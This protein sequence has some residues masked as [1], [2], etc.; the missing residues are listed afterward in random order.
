[1]AKTP[2]TTSPEE[3]ALKD[4]E[5][6]HELKQKE[7]KETKLKQIPDYM[8]EWAKK[9]SGDRICKN[10]TVG[11]LWGQLSGGR[12]KPIAIKRAYEILHDASKRNDEDYEPLF[13]HLTNGHFKEF[14]EDFPRIAD[15]FESKDPDIRK[16]AREFVGQETLQGERAFLRELKRIK[17]EKMDDKD[18]ANQ[19]RAA[20]DLTTESGTKAE[21]AEAMKGSDLGLLPR[22]PEAGNIPESFRK[23]TSYLEESTK[24]LNKVDDLVKEAKGLTES[25][26]ALEKRLKQDPNS[27]EALLTEIIGDYDVLKRTAETM[28][29]TEKSPELLKALKQFNKQRRTYFRAQA[30]ANLE[31]NETLHQKYLAAKESSAAKSALMEAAKASL[32]P[33]LKTTLELEVK[34]AVDEEMFE[35]AEQK[36]DVDPNKF[37]TE[38]EK[39]KAKYGLQEV[40]AP[41]LEQD[42]VEKM[43]AQAEEFI[44]FEAA[45]AGARK[46]YMDN[47]FELTKWQHLC[48]DIAGHVDMVEKKSGIKLTEKQDGW[49]L[50]PRQ[51]TLAY[52]DYEMRT[53]VDRSAI[54]EMNPD[55]DQTSEIVKNETGQAKIRRHQTATIK[56]IKYVPQSYEEGEPAEEEDKLASAWKPETPRKGLLKITIETAEGT[57]TMGQ[58]E[59]LNWVAT[60]EVHEEIQEPKEVEEKVQETTGVRMKLEKGAKLVG[61]FGYKSPPEFEVIEIDKVEGD[62]VYLTQPV[63]FQSDQEMPYATSL[64]G[65]RQRKDLSLGE[66][67]SLIARRDLLPL[68]LDSE[69]KDMVAKLKKD[70]KPFW[71]NYGAKGEGEAR[72]LQLDG[73]LGDMMDKHGPGILTGA[74]A[75]AGL[76]ATQME[77]FKNHPTFSER[78]LDSNKKRFIKTHV[79]GARLMQL[80]QDYD[81]TD[82]E[83][84]PLLPLGDAPET[85]NE[86]Y[87]TP[88]QKEQLKKE[89]KDEAAEADDE[90][91]D[92]DGKDP[93]HYREEALNESELES[94][95]EAYIT[96]VG[97]LRGLWQR[98]RVLASDDIWGL[99][100]ACY[101]HYERRWHRRSKEKFS[102]VGEQLPLGYGTEMSR[103]KQQAE[104][105]EVNQNVE[106]MEDWG[107]GDIQETLRNAKNID[108]LKACYQILA[109]KGH[110]RWDD[111]EMWKRLN[112]YVPNSKK[113]PIPPTDNPY[114]LDKKTNKTGLDYLEGAIDFLWG[115]GSYQ[116]WHAENN[117]TYNQKIKQYW[118][119]GKQLEGDPKNAGGIVSEL[120]RLL[121]N[122]KNGEYVD[123]HEYEGLIHFIIDYGKGTMEA[124][125]YYILEGVCI[126]SPTTGETLL[127]FDRIGSINGDYLNRLPWMDYLVRRDVPRPD[128][129]V[130]AWTLADFRKWC[131]EWDS[132]A[133]AGKPSWPNQSVIDFVWN[134][135][136]TDERSIIRNNKGLRKAEEMDHD[137][138]HFIIPLADEDLVT[139]VCQSASGSKRYFT[140]EGYNNAYPGYNQ[141]AKTLADR[142]E[143]SKLLNT[144]RGFA[145]FNSI[146]DGRYKK[147]QDNYA[148]LGPSFWN[149]PSVVDS[150]YTGWHKKQ[151]EELLKKIAYSYGDKE[152]IEMAE[153]MHTHT[154]SVSKPENAKIQKTVQAALD[155]FGTKL[156]KVVGTDGGRKM[157]SVV[158]SFGLTGMPEYISEEEKS[159]RQKMYGEQDELSQTFTDWQSDSN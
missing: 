68:E 92:L 21:T 84:T 28:K 110:I 27:V 125:M 158:S 19:V 15:A 25:K 121:Q 82:M 147:D 86:D 43:K 22:P 153:I 128:G 89:E 95:G 81:M 24:K 136:L 143:K 23:L 94:K 51:V 117:S 74:T 85:P 97:Y 58:K 77:A 106:A 33:L 29:K 126:E 91:A 10:K 3:Q 36:R 6:A 35:A 76:T 99:M 71:F 17:Q 115:Q 152:L 32:A 44:Q 159:M 135:V 116:D 48:I 124:K 4:Y 133:V 137:D 65:D 142:G 79:P 138:A 38:A 54:D 130:G 67:Y 87:L 111:I 45:N 98:T 61:I 7:K 155:D 39:I 31:A 104:T 47:S 156:E 75:T 64:R 11:D 12:V 144:L 154:G 69:A 37:Q 1:M 102:M 66:M 56:E 9:H 108:Q 42:I 120:A 55:E 20:T 34:R 134:N 13:E 78:F 50:Y 123:P 93:Q 131:A 101:E 63:V 59:F 103:I 30:P 118:E 114:F 96:Q 105:E 145:R 132:H 41:M 73:T 119:K 83:E 46:E 18:V 141:Y 151:M 146:M 16:F 60:H 127:S 26:T 139:N 109:K 5:I 112:M 2:N 90:K 8:H 149:R 129:T 40:Q 62:R 14:G 100:K 88:E 57:E 113:I 53:R 157:M 122:H 150:R 107:V 70:P 140:T 52:K 72:W 80:Q 49:G 148:R